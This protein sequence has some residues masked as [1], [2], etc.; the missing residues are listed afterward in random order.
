MDDWEKEDYEPDAPVVAVAGDKWDGE[1]ADDGGKD[2]WDDSD[3]ENKPESE[4]T[5]GGAYQRPK[6]K[7]LAERIAEKNRQKVEAAAASRAAKKEMSAEDKLSE[8]IRL[9]RVQEEADLKSAKELFGVG[10]SASKGAI[11]KMY[12]E[13][14]EEF[15]QLAEALKAKITFFE[16]SKEYGDFV[17]K[18]IN[19]VSVTLPVEVIKK[20]GVT[21]NTLYHEKER[22]RKEAAKS[23][24]KKQKAVV[25]IERD[26]LGLADGSGADYF[27]DGEDF[28]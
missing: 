28:I 11:D 5:E 20:I 9:Q 19:E 25:R 12:P 16:S 17:E 3:D 10:D 8:K 4:Q 27:D 2:N 26:D 23:K 14:K 13:T 15:D 21:L 6:K 22:Q 18:L 1:D 7:P 24:K